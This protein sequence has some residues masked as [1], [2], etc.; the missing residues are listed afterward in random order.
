VPV[1]GLKDVLIQALVLHLPE[2]MCEKG[3]HAYTYANRHTRTHR[4][5]LPSTHQR[6][7]I[8]DTEEFLRVQFDLPVLDNR[9]VVFY[10]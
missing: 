8:T 2:R 9:D 3:T 10:K 4:E 6:L 7:Q 5:A 1:L